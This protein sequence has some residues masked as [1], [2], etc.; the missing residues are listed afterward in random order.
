MFKYTSSG[1]RSFELYSASSVG[2]ITVYNSTL[3]PSVSTRFTLEYFGNNQ[4][5]SSQCGANC[6]DTFSAKISAAGV[7]SSENS[8]FINGNCSVAGTS[9]YTCTFNSGIFTTSPN[10]QA[11][12]LNNTNNILALEFTAVTSSSG[13]WYTNRADTSAAQAS[14]WRLECQKTGADF[15][16]TRTIQGSFKEVMVATGVTKPKTCYYAF[17]GASATLASPTECTTGTCVEVY[18]SCG[19]GTP[20]AFSSTGVYTGFSFASGT[21]ANSAYVHCNCTAWDLTAGTDRECNMWTGTNT[22][23]S[24][25]SGGFALGSYSTVS[26]AGTPANTYGQIKCEGSAP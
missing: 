2:T 12:G 1:D 4:V 9:Q 20:P 17:G 18:D 3:S 21:F 8:D 13:V 5:Y 10:C 15:V 19:T 6:V 24:N 22:W 16:A 26:V 25:S 11:T 7:V 23:A 14:D